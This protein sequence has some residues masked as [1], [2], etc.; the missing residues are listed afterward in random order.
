MTLNKTYNNN[1]LS[2][3]TT[4]V[5]NTFDFSNNNNNDKSRKTI[6]QLIYG[7]LKTKNDNERNRTGG[8][9]TLGSNDPD[10]NSET[11]KMIENL[12]EL[13][14]MF[15]ID[16]LR[17]HPTN[18]DHSEDLVTELFDK[19]TALIQS[20][21]DREKE[22]EKEKKNNQKE[23]L[24]QQSKR[25]NQKYMKVGTSLYLDAV[26]ELQVMFPSIAIKSVEKILQENNG[27]IEDAAIALLEL[28]S[29]TT[30][31]AS[32]KQRENDN[33]W[34]EESSIVIKV[35]R[36][37]QTNSNDIFLDKSDVLHYTRKNGGDYYKTLYDVVMNC[38]SMVLTKQQ[39][40]TSGGATKTH[41]KSRNNRR[42]QR[43]G[44]MGLASSTRNRILH[45]QEPQN[46]ISTTTPTPSNYRYDENSMEAKELWSLIPVSKDGKNSVELISSQKLPINKKF[47]I[48]ALEFFQGNVYKVIELISELS[49]SQ[50]SSS[51]Q[52]RHL[53]EKQPVDIKIEN[54]K[55]G[56]PKDSSNNT[57]IP[58]STREYQTDRIILDSHDEQYLFDRYLKTGTVD[59]HGF[60]VVEA[61]ELVP[62]ILHHWWNQELTHRQSI[63]QLEKFGN[64]ASLG[65]VLIITGRGVHSTGGV[66]TVKVSVNRYLTNNNY[67]FEQP[68][69][70]SFEVTGKRINKK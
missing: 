16:E 22:K 5:T 24:L 39:E 65:S 60:T 67:I 35:C 20:E 50:I 63:G 31:A 6:Y 51:K 25:Y 33:E 11:I 70:G 64:L 34:V 61:M 10:I 21:K 58:S 46:E 7:E 26:Y 29:G 43:G 49:S 68:T 48:K 44:A 27:N 13:F 66:S 14:P 47:A 30:T 56:M 53:N 36:F 42:V 2:Y 62:L 55:F 3:P 18:V 23:P 1:G 32:Q 41:D 9:Y 8:K 17:D 69:S 12:C 4:N 19:A 57:F 45:G 52:S 28:S 40:S 37:L 54:S 38:K 59:L 15:T